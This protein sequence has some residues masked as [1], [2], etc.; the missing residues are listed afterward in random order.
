M[1][2]GSAKGKPRTGTGLLRIIYPVLCALAARNLAASV[3]YWLFEGI[4]LELVK[5]PPSAVKA[6]R[7]AEVEGLAGVE[8]HVGNHLAAV[9]QVSVVG[10]VVRFP[11]RSLFDGFHYFIP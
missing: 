8:G 6:L 7:C 4:G 5:G 10:L 11:H 9:E 2:T 3:L 1:L